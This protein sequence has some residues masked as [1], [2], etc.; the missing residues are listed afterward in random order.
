MPA[1]TPRAT[2][3]CASSGCRRNVGAAANH[4]VVLRRARGELFKWA[5][6]DDLYAADLVEQCVRLLD[7]HPDAV[8]AHSWTAA[9]DED[10]TVIQAHEYPL[11]HRARRAPRAAAQHALRR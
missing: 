9:V 7:Q 2:P 8:L 4:D 10:G 1:T 6:A 11:L 5:S 3:G